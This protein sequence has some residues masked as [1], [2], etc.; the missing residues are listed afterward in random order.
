[1][2]KLTCGCLN[3]AIHIKETEL[4]TLDRTT[5]GLSKEQLKYEFFTQE[6][7]TV[8]LDLGGITK[9][10]SSLI[11]ERRIADWVT[12]RCNNCNMAVYALHATKGMDRVLASVQLMSNSADIEELKKSEYYSPL[13][14][15]VCYHG[16]T[17]RSAA[18]G[19]PITG[20]H[21]V[22]KTTINSLQQQLATYLA[23]EKAAMEERIRQY[24]EQQKEIYMKLQKKAYTD[25]NA[26]VGLILE[27]EEQK[28]KDSLSDAMMESPL[29]PPNRTLLGSSPRVTTMV[30][31]PPGQRQIHKYGELSITP[32]VTSSSPQDSQ[33]DTNSDSERSPTMVQTKPRKN[34][35]ADTL[36]DLDGFAEDCEPF[37]ESEDDDGDDNSLNEESNFHQHHH[38]SHHTISSRR[39]QPQQYAQSVPISMPM[40]NS[41]RRSFDDDDEKVPVPEPDKMVASMKAL[42]Q[43]VHDGTEMFG[44]LPRPRL[45]T[46][47]FKKP[48]P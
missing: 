8:N 7:T 29:S 6:L 24:T 22:V 45:N 10:Q 38:H 3:I 19:H 33:I 44:D 11:E 43:S 27:M 5:L 46:G 1:M 30:R 26:V 16:N 14:R 17:E 39:P 9:E 37:F 40:W 20:N 25:K 18:L 23:N 21:D 34:R 48:R 36:F 31:S 2:A 35:D 28:L 12:H 42:A 41:D 15:I 32:L 4:K 13:Y 47:D